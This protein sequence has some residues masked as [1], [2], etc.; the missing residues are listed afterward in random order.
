MS[1]EEVSQIIEDILLDKKANGS[2][3][4]DDVDDVIWDVIDELEN[5]DEL[6]DE[7]LEA[8]AFGWLF[9]NGEECYS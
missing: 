6:W 9:P 3:S 5:Q 7:I 8:G 4:Q 2:V 1:F